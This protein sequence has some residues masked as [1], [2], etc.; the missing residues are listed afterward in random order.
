MPRTPKARA[1]GN[2]LRRERMKKGWS[3]RKFAYHLGVTDP[4][5]ISRWETGDRT[6]KPE[7]VSHML[8]ALGLKGEAHNEILALAYGTKASSWIATNLPAQRQQ[9]AALLDFEQHSTALAH[10]APLLVPG[11]LQT[12]DYIRAIMHGLPPGEVA[13]R[14]AIRL[15]RRDILTRHNPIRYT[16]LVGEAALRQ[17]IGNRQILLD[18]L[19][20]LVEMAQRHSNIDLRVVPF[21][22]DWHPG[23]AGNCLLIESKE[24]S[25]VVHLE[26]HSSGL[27]L[28]EDEDVHEFRRAIDLVL[29]T[30]LSRENSM[31]F[32]AQLAQRMETRK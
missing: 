22:T 31:R 15:G 2:A 30:A 25:P 17:V 13:T 1:L 10:V 9:L 16:T 24:Y 20:H 14:V 26:L 12:E 18:Q 6:P 3:L 32:I 5:V 28:H 4:G 11:L 8:A 21:E 23:L 7:T 19:R 27:F 29:D